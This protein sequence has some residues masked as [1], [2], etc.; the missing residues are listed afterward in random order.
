[1]PGAVPYTSTLALTNVTLPYVLKLAN[2]G[3]KVATDRYPDL[4]KGLNIVHGE[5]VY[6]ELAETF[7]FSYLVLFV[8][9]KSHC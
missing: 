4:G 3:W 1:M 9:L 2:L 8:C 5:I 6:K 7:N